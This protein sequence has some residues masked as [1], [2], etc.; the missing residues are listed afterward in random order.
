MEGGSGS[1]GFFGHNFGIRL[2]A[3]RFQGGG[4]GEG[5]CSLTIAGAIFDGGKDWI[6]S[7]GLG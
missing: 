5:L 1:S 4:S 3:E 6:K 7:L 2:K